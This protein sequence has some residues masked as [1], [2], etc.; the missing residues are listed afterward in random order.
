MRRLILLVMVALLATPAGIIPTN[1]TNAAEKP[2]SLIQLQAKT[3]PGS[4]LLS[5]PKAGQS[6][7]YLYRDYVAD[8]KPIATLS[9]SDTS[10]TDKITGGHNYC[11][12]VIG[13]DGSVAAR[14]NPLPVWVPDTCQSSDGTVIKLWIEKT[15]MISD[16]SESTIKVAPMNYIGSTYVSIRPIIEAAGGQLQWNGDTRT[17]TV[18]LSPN[19]VALT[20]NSPIAKV[21]GQDKNISTNPK[22]VP[23]INKGSTMLPFRFIVENLGGSVNY[24]ANEKRLDI[25]LPLQP[26]KAIARIMTGFA[27]LSQGK[28]GQMVD[29]DSVETIN[30]KNPAEDF[31]SGAKVLY[32]AKDGKPIATPLLDVVDVNG[33]KLSLTNLRAMYENTSANLAVYKVNIKSRNS[34]LPSFSSNVLFNANSGDIIDATFL[35]S[36]IGLSLEQPI[37]TMSPKAS[38][39]INQTFASYKLG[40]SCARLTNGKIEFFTNYV[41]LTASISG[42]ITTQ[43]PGC[44]PCQ[45]GKSD[46]Y[47][48]FKNICPD[49][50][51]P[52]AKLHLPIIS[53]LV[54]F[55]LE[56]NDQSEGVD[57]SLDQGCGFFP[58]SA[59]T[60][61][62]DVQSDVS[63]EVADYR[64]ATINDNTRVAATPV[65]G[66][67]RLIGVTGWKPETVN[68]KT[69]NY[70]TLKLSDE[71]KPRSMK[72]NFGNG[73]LVGTFSLSALMQSNYPGN[74]PRI[75]MRLPLLSSPVGN[76]VGIVK[77]NMKPKLSVSL[78]FEKIGNWFAA[79]DKKIA[80]FG[81]GEFTAK[82]EFDCPCNG[83]LKA[84][85]DAKLDVEHKGDLNIVNL[86]FRVNTDVAFRRD[87]DVVEAQL[88]RNDEALEKVKV[89]MSKPEIVLTDDKPEIGQTYTYCVK[90]FVNSEEIDQWCNP[91][92]IVPAPPIFTIAWPDRSKKFAAKIMAGDKYYIKVM[93]S[94]LSESEIKVTLY[95]NPP[96]G[97]WKAYFVNQTLTTVVTVPPNGT[98][99][100]TQITVIPD[101]GLAGGEACEFSVEGVSGKQK[102]SIKLK[103]LTEAV[104]C[105]YSFQWVEGGSAI[106]GTTSAG[107]QNSQMLMLKN[108]GNES[109]K[110]VIDLRFD[111]FDSQT[112]QQ[113]NIRF[114]ENFTPGTSV[115]L[116]PGEVMELSVFCRPSNDMPDGE[117]VKISVTVDG[118]GSKS[119][120]TWTLTNIL[121]T[122]DFNLE[123][124]KNLNTKSLKTYAGERFY[125]NFTVTNNM[126]DSALLLMTSE[127]KG[128]LIDTSTQFYELQLET[129]ESK[130]V[131]LTCVTNQKVRIGQ[132]K[133]S[134]TVS[135]GK[136]TKTIM[137][138]YNIVK[139]EECDYEIAWESNRS[140]TIKSNMP[141]DEPI[142]MTIWVKNKSI[143]EQLLAVK[144]E[145][146][147]ESWESGIDNT[148][149]KLKQTFT[150]NPGEETDGLVVFVSAGKETKVG[151]KCTVKVSIKACNTTKELKWDVACVPHQD[152]DVQF[153]GIYDKPTW[154]TDGKLN[155]H[156]IFSFKRQGIGLIKAS[157][158]WFEFTNPSSNDAQLGSTEKTPL[159]LQIVDGMT[160]WTTN[161]KIPASVINKVVAQ[162]GSEIKVKMLMDFDLDKNK[163]MSTIERS[164][165][166][167]IKIPAK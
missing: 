22:I 34:L 80:T 98:N 157:Q 7:I 57:I 30:S 158:Y 125:V 41:P 38:S 150:L 52:N 74:P 101:I 49:S 68:D 73:G 60:S 87:N 2:Y 24:D 16:C 42:K 145:R 135:C 95:L 112:K 71:T 117:K 134:V 67:V 149:S 69:K 118:C 97:G 14:S 119:E 105:N 114:G 37:T 4:V 28:L 163:V 111:R 15:K 132:S 6:T 162:G 56:V 122:C 17:A 108:T 152:L 54:D 61:I 79:E 88:F 43:S 81:P 76:Q 50:I 20:I 12:M 124:D 32:Y 154:T 123:W 143:N 130:V 27:S 9:P 66:T 160:P 165:I 161:I 25:T 1:Q 89:S 29:I 72:I 11:L 140:N 77:L 126:D 100:T 102:Q 19:I 146:T 8:A 155:V 96:C 121:S 53:N 90:L 62:T 164:I 103:A 21:N 109:N 104:L 86:S 75:Q 26:N 156:S 148:L 153:S 78:P 40:Y 51:N 84:I 133:I 129:G 18:I 63:F 5:W 23:I 36:T 10:Y 46:V 151:D 127:S 128:E 141:I 13:K 92:S 139:Q 120:L 48:E 159:N 113:W 110:F 65:K 136:T 131:R 107:V 58:S 44:T 55:S 59:C 167:T 144:I 83:S 147:D 142:T 82:S 33:R 85:E 93:V 45:L 91:E 99:Q 39:Q 31:C 115:N 138:T 166:F 35:P 47:L 64:P 116:E 70:I 3:E 106:G 137:L 94:N